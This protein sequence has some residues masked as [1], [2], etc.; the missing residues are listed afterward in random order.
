MAVAITEALVPNGQESTACSL[1]KQ[2]PF[3][4]SSNNLASV[5][6]D[7]TTSVRHAWWFSEWLQGVPPGDCRGAAGSGTVSEHVIK[8]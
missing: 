4:R 2:S 3:N 8:K 5:S 7:L 6:A 1:R